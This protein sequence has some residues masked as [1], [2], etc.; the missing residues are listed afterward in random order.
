MLLMRI[1][2]WDARRDGPLSEPALVQKL[3]ARGY[4]V[5]R[6][7]YPGGTVAAGQPGADERIQAVVSGL[8]KVTID[9]ESAI[10]TAGDLVFIPRGALRRLEVLGPSSAVCLEGDARVN[11]S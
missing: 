5:N 10:L 8:L 9:G 3:E 1:E 2:R 11:L 4:Q 6:R 7:H